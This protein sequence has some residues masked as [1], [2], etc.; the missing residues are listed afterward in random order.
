MTPWKA[1]CR[2]PSPR[3]AVLSL[4]M[5][6]LASCDDRTSPSAE[7]AEHSDFAVAAIAPGIAFA[8]AGLQPA[9]LSTVHTGTVSGIGPSGMLSYLSALRAKGGRV[10]LRLHGEG[11]VRN[12]DNTFN[13]T[14]WKA[15]VARFRNINFSSYINDGTIVAHHMVDEPHFP[16]R[17]G[18]KTI[19]QATL[20][21]MAQYSKQL[22][23]ILTTAVGA[24]S[25]YLASSPITYRYLDTAWSTY[26]TNMG[27]DYTRWAARQVTAAK[28]KGLGLIAGLNVLDGGNGSS[29]IRGTLPKKWTMSA[30]E[31][32]SY[33]SAIL[34]QSHVCAFFMWRYQATYYDRADIKS[35]MAALSLKARN[36]ARTSCRQ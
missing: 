17:W 21:A 3:F 23:P 35:A 31:L 4:T 32:R 18:G 34:A 13:L 5:I 19:P 14:K 25:T 9:Q 11:M 2:R 29:G 24:P 6:T 12:E 16:S 28:S 20:E 7:V 22:Y 15:Q 27:S 30:T 8:S 26:W 10:I 36:H 33:G 1:Y